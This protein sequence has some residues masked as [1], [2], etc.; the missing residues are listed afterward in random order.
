MFSKK[1]DAV[2][3]A[4]IQNLEAMP[5]MEFFTN[6]I[7]QQSQFVLEWNVTSALVT[8]VAL[9]TTKNIMVLD[10]IVLL[11]VNFTT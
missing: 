11:M 3:V 6:R 10:K 5:R 1:N 9:V 8:P 2:V 7:C 4:L